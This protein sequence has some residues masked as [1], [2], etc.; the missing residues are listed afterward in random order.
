M[1]KTLSILLLAA[2]LI[3]FAP[4]ALATT[5]MPHPGY[6]LDKETYDSCFEISLGSPFNFDGKAFIWKCT[7]DEDFEKLF[8]DMA[9]ASKS[10]EVLTE[11]LGVT[12]AAFHLYDGTY[13]LLDID[14]YAPDLLFII[15]YE[16][17]IEFVSPEAM[18][19]EVSPK[20]ERCDGCRGSGNCFHCKG[21]GRCAICKGTGKIAKTLDCNICYGLGTCSKCYGSGECER[22]YGTGFKR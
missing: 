16:S 12:V 20:N 22:C 9:K 4:A 14:S 17:D 15:N 19:E 3:T 8:D 11:Q 13:F 1:K 18:Q 2:L 21:G 10:V 5:Q 6:Y 7:D